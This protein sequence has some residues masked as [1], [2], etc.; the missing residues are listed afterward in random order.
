MPTQKIAAAR[1]IAKA[2]R[3]SEDM[4]DT[5]IVNAANLIA[6]I[7]EARLQSGVAAETGH[8]AF[9]RAAA[10]LQALSDA[11]DHVVACHRELAGVRDVQGI[12]PG[13]AGCTIKLSEQRRPRLVQSRAA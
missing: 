9:M 4:I 13:E 11:R 7:A 12:D 8:D 3:P 5:S 6:T 1:A 10:S 2:L